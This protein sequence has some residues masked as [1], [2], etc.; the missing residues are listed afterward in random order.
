MRTSSRTVKFLKKSLHK[1]FYFLSDNIFDSTEVILLSKV[2]HRNLVGLVGFCEEF[3]LYLEHNLVQH[4]TL[5]FEVNMFHDVLQ[6]VQ[7][8]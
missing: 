6:Q 8:Y 2:K 4:E 5:N 1:T 3:G 7:K